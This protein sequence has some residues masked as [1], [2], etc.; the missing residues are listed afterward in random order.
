MPPKVKI[1]KEMIENASFEVI[2]ERG[3]ENLSARTIAEYL[4]CSTQPV[5]YSFRTVD[6]IR[7]AAYG[8]ADRYHTE[9]I[10]P[11]GIIQSSSCRRKRTRF[12]S[13]RWD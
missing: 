4:K 13:L 3:H 9:F 8:I 5:L 7:E 11:T 12:R 6:E 10:M 2:R 1:T